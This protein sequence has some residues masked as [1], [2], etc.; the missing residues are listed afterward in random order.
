MVWPKRIGDWPPRLR[1]DCDTAHVNSI[2]CTTS[3][4]ASRPTTPSAIRKER[5]RYQRTGVRGSEF[6]VRGSGSLVLWFWFFGSLVLV[7]G[8]G[9]RFYA[10]PRYQTV[11]RCRRGVT[12]FS[13][14]RPGAALDNSIM[15]IAVAILTVTLAPAPP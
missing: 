8:S 7:L 1:P 3:I 11:N 4:A 13:R 15:L 6:G 2:A 12:V 14:P 9:S 10:N 5:L